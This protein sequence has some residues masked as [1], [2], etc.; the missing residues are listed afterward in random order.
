VTV[1]YNIC[2]QG[3]TIIIVLGK[4]L[5]D[6]NTPSHILRSRVKSS[7]ELFDKTPN[8]KL[9]MSG[10]TV[11]GD[12][13]EAQVMRDLATSEGVPEEDILIEAQ[14]TNT[15]EN[16]A[17]SRVLVKKLSPD[18]ICIVT[19]DFHMPRAKKVFEIIFGD[20]YAIRCVTDDAELTPEEQSF[21]DRKE[22]EAILKVEEDIE[23]FRQRE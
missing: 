12:I 15:I 18:Q 14:S 8:S 2:M 6:D 10:G 1:D 9:L 11:A 4:R 17:S 23:N 3:S 20:A 13:P 19:S 21:E 5:N 7:C 16:A 22:S